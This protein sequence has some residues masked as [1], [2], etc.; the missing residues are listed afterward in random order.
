MT[1]LGSR[2][3]ALAL[4]AA[5]L[6]IAIAAIPARAASTG[7]STTV[8]LSPVSGARQFFVEDLAGH[9]LTSL[10][11]GNGGTLPFRV[12]VVDSAY[13][14]A[15][16]QFT[17]SATLNN[18]Y[19]RTAPS[20]YSFPTMVPSSSVSVGFGGAPLTSF[21]LSFADLPS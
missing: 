10:A 16:E 5:A 17:V 7:H 1:A 21:G 6:L 20:T 13:S 14:A 11:F 3:T 4:F 2:R 15:T 8:S 9:D 19:L 18:L 12:R